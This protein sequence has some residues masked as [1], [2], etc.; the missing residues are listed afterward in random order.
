[1][2]IPGLLNTTGQ[3]ALLCGSFIVC[4][5]LLESE[6]FLTWAQRLEVSERQQ[7]AQLVATALNNELKPLG[8]GALRGKALAFLDQHGWNKSNTEEQSDQ[9]A[10]VSEAPK[11]AA[12]Q[13]SSA[14]VS[15]AFAPLST[16]SAPSAS[17]QEAS[18]APAAVQVPL[19]SPLPI[20]ASAT[21]TPLPPAN[22]QNP[23]VVALAGDSMM[24]VGLGAQLQ[25]DLAPYPS[26]K[27]V[28]AFKSGT[29]LARP[30]VYN[31][32]KEYP[33]MLGKQNPEVVICSIGANDGQG[34]VE[35]GKVLPF[36]TREWDAVYE[37][38]VT[39][40]LDMLTR[41][42]AVVLW[43]Q[44]PPMK[45]G[46]FNSTID[47]INRLAQGVVSKNPRA[48]WWNP[49][50]RITQTNGQF[51]DF[52]QL[53]GSKKTVRIRAADGIHLS[54]EGAAIITPDIVAWLNPAPVVKPTKGEQSAPQVSSATSAPV[55]APAEESKPV[56][57]S[58]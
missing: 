2:R 40:F 20:V 33:A 13:T 38:R 44:L 29:G 27:V 47:R 14:P 4:I 9:P 1:M 37:A 42:G 25:R 55:Q 43:V 52:M 17:S 48:I 32:L 16:Q 19:A 18:S 28:R 50:P 35:G 21:L 36:G 7:N 12:S 49:S 56:A 30:E 5:A 54:D 11:T 34:F 58:L 45:S 22:V 46:K 8:I 57:S 53:A 24:A 41:N 6:G 10:P 3:L 23:R 15:A 26:I 51:S 39:Q 31:W